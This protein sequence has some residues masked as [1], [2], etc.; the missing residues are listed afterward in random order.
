MWH[1]KAARYVLPHHCLLFTTVIYIWYVLSTQYRY[2]HSDSVLSVCTAQADCE[3]DVNTTLR[4]SIRSLSRLE[5]QFC[6]K[7]QLYTFVSAAGMCPSCSLTTFLLM[8]AM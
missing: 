8:R 3:P 4:G 6:A 2:L 7:E 1:C 5:S